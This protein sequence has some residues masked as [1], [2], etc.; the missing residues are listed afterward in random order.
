MWKV[1]KG[2]DSVDN[3]GRSSNVEL[4]RILCILFIIGDHFTGQSGIFEG[5]TRK[6][7]FLLHSNKFVK[8]RM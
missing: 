4:L 7:Y 3:N 8:S 6:P 2:Q 1:K 5:G